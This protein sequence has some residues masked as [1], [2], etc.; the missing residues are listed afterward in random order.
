MSL[1]DE[2]IAVVHC[3]KEEIKNH[4]PGTSVTIEIPTCGISNES[5]QEV[6]PLFAP[7][8]D[9]AEVKLYL[10]SSG[11]TI[12]AVLT[13]KQEIEYRLQMK[14]KDSWGKSPFVSR[15]W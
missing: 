1:Q 11:R 7:L 15:K 9:E 3:W 5:F 12:R 13:R 10:V 4:I 14:Q 6:M 8:L 2:V